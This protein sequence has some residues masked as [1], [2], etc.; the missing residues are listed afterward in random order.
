MEMAPLAFGWD[1]PAGIGAPSDVPAVDLAVAQLDGRR[2]PDMPIACSMPM[3]LVR[4]AAMTSARS[5]SSGSLPDPDESR[6]GPQFVAEN[7]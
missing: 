3:T 7:R 5:S 1:P 2:G 4:L 6:C